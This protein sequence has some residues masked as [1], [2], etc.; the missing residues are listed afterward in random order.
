M[1]RLTSSFRSPGGHMP[2]FTVSL[3]NDKYLF[4][5][6]D[7]EVKVNDFEISA[8]IA[9]SNTEQPHLDAVQLE[10]LTMF[11]NGINIK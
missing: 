9:A 11:R 2:R 3:D 6:D 8:E 1:T 10:A 4:V 5:F 7:P